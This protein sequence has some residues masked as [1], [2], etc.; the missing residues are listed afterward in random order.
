MSIGLKNVRWWT[1]GNDLAEEGKFYWGFNQ[2]KT[3]T[4]WDVRQPDNAGGNEHCTEIWNQNGGFFWNDRPCTVE[5][6]FICEYYLNSRKV[7]AGN[8]TLDESQTKGPLSLD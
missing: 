1:A 5:N 8:L 6:L 2:R 7:G 4:N 3:Y